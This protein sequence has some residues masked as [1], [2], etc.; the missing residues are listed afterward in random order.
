MVFLHLDLRNSV[1]EDIKNSITEIGQDVKLTWKLL[2]H[3]A[4]EGASHPQSHVPEL[5]TFTKE[6]LVHCFNSDKNKLFLPLKELIK[7]PK[8]ES[9][10]AVTNTTLEKTE[11]TAL[12]ASPEEEEII[13]TIIQP[14]DVE[15]QAPSLNYKLEK[16]PKAFP[17]TSQKEVVSGID[18]TKDRAHL[19][20]AHIHKK[21]KN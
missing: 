13:G 1:P 19:K 14:E 6:I 16:R 8:G 7:K 17:S 2:R 3:A 11:V 10:G 4:R 18:N 9:K 5:R 20:A 15:G 12:N 21:H